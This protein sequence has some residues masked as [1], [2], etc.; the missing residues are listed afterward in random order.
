MFG[1]WVFD[2]FGKLFSKLSKQQ[3][4]LMLMMALQA[5]SVEPFHQVS[6]YS[7]H[8]QILNVTPFYSIRN[9]INSPLSS[10]Q[11]SGSTRK[12]DST[13]TT[14]P[15][16]S[17]TTGPISSTSESKKSQF[18]VLSFCNDPGRPYH[19]SISPVQL[20]YSENEQVMYT[21][22]DFISLKQYK[23]CVKGQWQGDMPICGGFVVH[24]IEST[25]L[26]NC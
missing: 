16:T 10:I 11:W 4:G 13:S 12:G 6:A 18:E 15:F 19:S 5:I 8:H 1:S 17:A 26:I 2:M 3:Y 9:Y 22:D 24:C 23:K 25:V 21:C 14:P 20:T 7:E